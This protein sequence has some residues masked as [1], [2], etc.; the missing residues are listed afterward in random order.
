MNRPLTE[1][2][3]YLILDARYESVRENGV[4]RSRAVWWP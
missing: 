3:P 1:E 2:Y 4:V